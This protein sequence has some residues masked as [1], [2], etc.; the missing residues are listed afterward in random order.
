[1]GKAE[2]DRPAS[3]LLAAANGKA[4]LGG[5]GDDGAK[6]ELAA[7]PL[8]PRAHLM[9]LQ[10]QNVSPLVQKQRTPTRRASSGFTGFPTSAQ[11]SEG[12]RMVPIGLYRNLDLDS[13]DEHSQPGGRPVIQLKRV[14]KAPWIAGAKS[15]TRQQA[16]GGLRGVGIANNGVA[17]QSYWN[18]QPSFE[19]A[20]RAESAEVVAVPPKTAQH[21]GSA[22]LKYKQ[23]KGSF[24]SSIP[25]FDA[26]R[27][28]QTLS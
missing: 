19:R 11:P 15:A 27:M 9:Q 22:S 24:G 23:G 26:G 8:R 10:T 12:G 13:V 25:R 17:Y 6:E 3:P 4:A 20:K 14:D 5:E 1:M 2:A 18:L 21:A 7:V 28:S 16:R